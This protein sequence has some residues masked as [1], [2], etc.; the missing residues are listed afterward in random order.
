MIYDTP[1]KVLEYLKYASIFNA[2]NKI[3]LTNDIKLFWERA[4]YYLIPHLN[5][6]KFKTG[7]TRDINNWHTFFIGTSKD[8]YKVGYLEY[9]YLKYFTSNNMQHGSFK[10]DVDRKNTRLYLMGKKI[11]YTGLRNL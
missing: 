11:P 6:G 10:D 4:R 3:Y 7:Q 9:K 2:L 5:L 1:E 8:F